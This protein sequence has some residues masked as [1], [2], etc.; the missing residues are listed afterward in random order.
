LRAGRLVLAET[1]KTIAKARRYR[2]ML[3]G[4]CD[5]ADPRGCRISLMEMTKRLSED[6]DNAKYMAKKPSH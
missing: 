3:G 6:H 4:G 1:Q 2:M 5:S